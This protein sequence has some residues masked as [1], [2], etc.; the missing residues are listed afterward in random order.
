MKIG[1]DIDNTITDTLPILRKYCIEYNEQV[2]KRNLKINEEGFASYNFFEWT[3]E[4]NKNFCNLYLKEVVMQATVKEDASKVI[5]KLREEGNEIIII[6][7][8][9]LEH[10]KNP[11]QI[12]K[13]FLEKN[14]I[15]YDELILS[16]PHKIEICLQKEIDIMLDDEPQNITEISEHIPVIVFEGPQN[17]KCNGRNIIKVQHWK[18]VDSIIHNK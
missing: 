5:R 6:T 16:T 14:E 13:S 4:E 7:A 15:E 18:E 17:K 2:V 12:T 10:F 1:I 9:S 3:E 11:Y 8:R